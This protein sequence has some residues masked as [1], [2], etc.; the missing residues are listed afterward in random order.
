M[1]VCV[2]VSVSVCACVKQNVNSR[3]D[4]SLLKSVE[5]VGTACEIKLSSKTGRH[6]ASSPLAYGG[7]MIFCIVA[8]AFICV[9]L[10]C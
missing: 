7:L 6:I 5:E 9:P 8:I 1:C 4:L 3:L 10:K 2:S